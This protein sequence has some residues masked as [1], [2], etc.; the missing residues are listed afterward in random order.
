MRSTIL[1][2]VAC[3]LLAG[4]GNKTGKKQ[5]HSVEA[6]STHIQRHNRIVS[7]YEIRQKILE[8][9][10]TTLKFEFH[11]RIEEFPYELILANK[12]SYSNAFYPVYSALFNAF[13]TPVI[14]S[15]CYNDSTIRAELI[16]NTS[17]D[18]TESMSAKIKILTK[19]SRSGYFNHK[20]FI[21]PDSVN[22][23]LAI[24]SLSRGAEKGNW[25]AKEDMAAACFMGYLV[26]RNITKGQ[27]WHKRYVNHKLK[28]VSGKDSSTVATKTNN[29]AASEI[30]VTTPQSK[31]P[32][33]ITENIEN[34][35]IKA[36]NDTK[37][38][39]K[40]CDSDFEMLLFSVI[41]ADK[42][43]YKPAYLDTY[44]YLW[45]TFNYHQKRDLWNLSDFDP[46]TK[47]YALYH[48]RKAASFGDKQA[49]DILSKV[50]EK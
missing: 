33:A 24:S 21:Y 38:D 10:D 26:K 22:S 20:K 50:K 32:S 5:V 27:F 49:N 37:A 45:K 15:Q 41:M 34:G 12:R 18:L 46:K 31:F 17:P 47:S 23:A 3:F 1:L 43:N 2:L 40:D 9:G 36:Y 42:Y 19:F 30:V 44:L 35:N 13:K 8:H 48:L 14:S 6:D 25:N 16:R 7:E 4:C 39:Y 11:G 29:Q 28:K